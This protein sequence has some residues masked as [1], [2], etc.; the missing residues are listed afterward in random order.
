[1][2]SQNLP[3]A[4]GQITC[5]IPDGTGGI[6]VS[7]SFSVLTEKPTGNAVNRTAI[8][9]VLANGQVDRAWNPNVVDGYSFSPSPAKVYAMAIENGILYMAGSFSSINGIQRNGLASLNSSTGVLNSWNPNTSNFP[10]GGYGRE[11]WNIAASNNRIYAKGNANPGIPNLFSVGIINTGDASI[12]ANAGTGNSLSFQ[13][14]TVANGVVYT[15][16]F[17]TLQAFDAV[18]GAVVPSFD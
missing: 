12:Q 16:G 7:G 6:F 14:I 17:Q 4:N 9:H 8:A 11:S 5:I 2:K 10:N 3:D 1:M 15:G 13:A 18:T